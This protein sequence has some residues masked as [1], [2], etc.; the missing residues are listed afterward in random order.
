MLNKRWIVFGCGYVGRSLAE[1]AVKLG[2]EV[3]ILSRNA[4]SLGQV[5]SVPEE[6]KI[7]ASL[8]SNDWHHALKGTWDM[9]V[10]LVSS[11]GGGLDGY[12]TSY[13]EGNQSILE[14]SRSVSI[15]RF[16][17]T[18]ATSVYPQSDG[19]WVHEED[20]P[21]EE[22]LS[23]SGRLLRE[24]ELRVM[25]GTSIPTTVILRLAGIYGPGRHLY[26][27]K[28]KERASV[29]SGD[30]SAWLNLIHLKDI[31]RAILLLADSNNL[32]TKEIFNLV[33]N[34]P[35]QKQ[36]IVDWLAAELNLPEIRFD[37]NIESTRSGKRGVAGV[38][39]NR[40]VSNSLI[41][42]KTGWRPECEDYR[43]GY[44]DILSR[45]QS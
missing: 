3:W 40:R 37:P 34:H 11:A 6:R 32:G 5:E 16:I 38:L 8:H 12:R 25:E 17:Y 44:R 28:L 13:I 4:E 45:N 29:I 14:W 39:P 42:A 19:S 1:A 2:Y 22:H 7:V 9:A 27:N 36:D 18:S 26:L 24:A 23:A 31:V 15:G 35:S 33:D 20:V 21:A 30:G 43:A 41:T 10:N